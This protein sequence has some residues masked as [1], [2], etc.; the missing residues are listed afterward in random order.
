MMCGA[1][2]R[3]GLSAEGKLWDENDFGFMKMDEYCK[4]LEM[5]VGNVDKPI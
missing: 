1:L 3:T 4:D 5:Q 2:H